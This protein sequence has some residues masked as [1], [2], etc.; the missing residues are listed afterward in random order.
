MAIGTGTDK[1]SAA[2]VAA[3]RR[4]LRQ[5]ARVDPLRADHRV[6]R[7]ACLSEARVWMDLRRRLRARFG[8]TGFKKGLQAESKYG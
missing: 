5:A 3:G 6:D 1:D 7:R 4:R 2:C 8:N